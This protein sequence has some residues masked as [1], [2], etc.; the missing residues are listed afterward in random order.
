MMFQHSI[1]FSWLSIS[2]GRSIEGSM[3]IL[4]QWFKVNRNRVK[5]HIFR[6]RAKKFT[7]GGCDD[8]IIRIKTN[9]LS[10][11]NFTLHKRKGS[12][13]PPDP[14]L[15]PPRYNLFNNTSA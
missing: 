15:A 14:L 8:V 4:Q 12:K 11:N 5:N 13:S 10:F 2:A 6:G 7:V 1:S 3:K 9:S